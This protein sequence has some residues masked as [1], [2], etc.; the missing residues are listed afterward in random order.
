[1]IAIASHIK[2]EKFLQKTIE[3]LLN[4]NTQD[5]IFIYLNDYE[6][7]PEWMPEGVTAILGKDELGDLGAAAKFY[8]TD[9]HEGIYLT[10]DDDLIYSPGYIGYL[11]DMVYRYNQTTVVGLHGT[12][13]YNHPVESYYHGPGRVI[14][15]C[16]NGL[17]KDKPVHML[18]TGCLAFDTRYVKLS[19]KDF[20]EPRMT[21]PYFYKFSQKN[22]VPLVCLQRVHGFVR[23]QEGSQGNAI[24]KDLLK[25]DKKQ[26]SIIN[27]VELQKLSP[28]RVNDS[29]FGNASIEWSTYKRIIDEVKPGSKVVEFGTGNTTK[30]LKR[31]F[32]LVSVEEDEEWLKDGMI[33]APLKNDWYS[34]LAKKE[35]KTDVKAYLIDGPK[36]KNRINILNHLDLLNQ[37]AI[38][39]VDDAHRELDRELA[40]TLAREFGKDIELIYGKDKAFAVLK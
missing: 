31:K 22:K 26:T 7:V 10:A 28:S 19:V 27:S 33:H 2:R 15:Y 12:T 18:G 1:M 36:G 4:N 17:A 11:T 3:S 8:W 9:K 29:D 6:A 39:F 23:E 30:Y 35:I 40:E 13:Y 37:K 25:G 24:W 14:E 5:A 32:E 20:P 38:F 16:Y 34:G 21:D